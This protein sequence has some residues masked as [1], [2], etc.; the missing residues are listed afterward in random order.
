MLHGLSHFFWG[1]TEEYCPGGKH[2]RERLYVMIGPGYAHA[3][4]DAW[5]KREWDVDW[6]ISEALEKQTL[7]GFGAMRWRQ[8]RERWTRRW[9]ALYG[10]VRYWRLYRK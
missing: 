3:D 7:R 6:Y 4:Y 10:R 1:L 8:W 5:V 2:D 9:R